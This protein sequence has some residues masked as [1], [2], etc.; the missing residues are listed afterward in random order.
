MMPYIYGVTP[1]KSIFQ[2]AGSLCE[3]PEV[4]AWK[5][6]VGFQAQTRF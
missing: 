3:E 4:Q 6:G 5:E 1:L 2:V